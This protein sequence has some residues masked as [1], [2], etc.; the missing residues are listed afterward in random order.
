MTRPT[1]VTLS[2]GPQVD[3]EKCVSM[4]GNR[5]DMVIVAATRAREIKRR[6]LLAERIDHI[7][8]A[9]QALLEIQEGKIGIEYLKKVK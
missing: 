4:I 9:V 2:R 8:P 1:S 7:D 6:H 5:F 3:T